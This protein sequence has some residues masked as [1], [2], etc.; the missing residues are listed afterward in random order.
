MSRPIVYRLYLYL[1]LAV[2]ILFSG[3]ALR[4]TDLRTMPGGLH[5]DETI[6][7]YRAWRFAEG[8]GMPLYFYDAPEPFD[9]IVR[10]VWLRLTG[11]TPFAS[12]IFSI[13]LGLV[14][15]AATAAAA[16]SLFRSHPFRQEMALV[17]MLT[18]GMIPAYVIISRSIY[19]AAWVAPMPMLA[20]VLIIR[21]WRSQ[22]RW[23]FVLAGILTA[24]A[25]L[26]YLS[27]LLFPPAVV[28]FV[29]V[30]VVIYRQPLPKWRNLA[31]YGLAFGAMML[32]WLYLFLVIPH[33]LTTRL[34]VL[35]V[36]NPL[37]NPAGFLNGVWQYV[38]SIVQP[39]EAAPR[40]IQY[41]VLTM[42][43][44][45]PVLIV[46]A[47]MGVGVL[48]WR[49]RRPYRLYPL[50]LITLFPLPAIISGEPDHALR[51]IGT[52][53]PLALMVAA[54]AGMFL[55][56]L[57][58]WRWKYYLSAALVFLLA[59]GSSVQTAI[60]LRYHYLENLL[61][62]DPYEHSGINA[63]YHQ[64][65]REFNRYLAGSP[66]PV[67][68]PVHVMAHPVAVVQLRPD[69]FPVVRGLEEGEQLPQAPIVFPMRGG[70][71]FPPVD[72]VHQ[73][74]LLLPDKGEIVLLPAL[75]DAAARKLQEQVEATGTPLYTP[76]NGWQIG[77][78]LDTSIADAFRDLH[79]PIIPVNAVFDDN[80]ELVAMDAPREMAP[81]QSTI[82]TFFMRLKRPTMTDYF[83]LVQAFDYEGNSR[84]SSQGWIHN[85]IYPTPMW[86]P[87]QL[88][89]LTVTMGLFD[90]APAGAY[91]YS[92][93][94]YVKP[95]DEF[96]PVQD[97]TGTVQANQRV[98]VGRFVVPLPPSP[99]PPENALALDA[100]IGDILELT[101][102]LFEPPL[103][104]LKP[105][106]TFQAALFWHVLKAPPE[107][108]TLFVHLQDSEERLL[109]QWDGRPFDGRY[110]TGHWLPDER[111]AITVTLTLPADAHGALNLHTGWYNPVSLVRLPAMQNGQTTSDNRIRLVEW[112]L[113]Q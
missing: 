106:D 51:V 44:L 112:E 28:L 87:G 1:A 2:F 13:Y 39:S 16:K 56:I 108:Y 70:Y 45:N 65:F 22:R 49:W 53:A 73:Y 40:I 105:G 93:G 99:P 31:A 48:V 4:I 60:H 43:Y 66:T 25:T 83:L 68:V 10:S 46:C 101:N 84:G 67:Y 15:M 9:A 37:Q 103:E 102:V 79:R 41:T 94:V 62:H 86:Q 35:P 33:W 8:Y 26:F 29:L 38:L 11:I 85:W 104:Q 89:P 74:A 3:Y 47:V 98:M 24:L 82:A 78:T 90:D 32:P 63:L 110:P 59:A 12:E 30:N 42:G 88:I 107:D 55:T 81:G 36:L 21:A 77:Y 111:I 96:V 100:Q 6:Y 76:G 80:L 52:Y 95:R 97:F 57:G 17:A 23:H 71:D 64:G 58:H 75:P 54:G 27:G 20:M 19:R 7:M 109:A 113:P 18:V 69:I 92:V 72:I 50:I 61:I 14:C 34:D 5:Y 91:R